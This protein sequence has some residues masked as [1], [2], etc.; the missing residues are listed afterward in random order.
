MV[1]EDEYLIARDLTEQLEVAGATVLGP[2]ATVDAATRIINRDERIDAA[3]LDVKLMG[4]V[5][6]PVADTLRRRGVPILFATGYDRDSLAPAFQDVLLCEKPL[7]TSRVLSL[8]SEQ[9][10][11]A[12]SA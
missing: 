5:V 1:V 12:P 3:V 11:Q 8:L 2:V 4:A 7:E 10:R 9:L 6:Y